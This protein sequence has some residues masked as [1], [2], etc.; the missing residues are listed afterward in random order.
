MIFH[1]KFCYD[2]IHPSLRARWYIDWLRAQVWQKLEHESTQS[3]LIFALLRSHF[4]LSV[5]NSLRDDD[6]SIPE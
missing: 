6:G 5:T 3:H 4:C 1:V 2:C